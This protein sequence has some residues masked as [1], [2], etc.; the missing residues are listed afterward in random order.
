MSLPLTSKTSISP[1][2]TVTSSAPRLTKNIGFPQ[3]IWQEFNWKICGLIEVEAAFFGESFIGFIPDKCGLKGRNAVEQFV[4]IAHSWDYSR[5]DFALEVSV[6]RKAVYLNCLFWAKHD[7]S[8][9]GVDPALKKAALAGLIEAW[10]YG[11]I[12]PNLPP[13]L[14]KASSHPAV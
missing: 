10:K 7:F 1:S 2:S 12:R 14:A 3:V 13:A 9:F 6:N 8:K 4:A 5:M 11:E